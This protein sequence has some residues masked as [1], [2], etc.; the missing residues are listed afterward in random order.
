MKTELPDRQKSLVQWVSQATG[1]STFGVKV[2]LQ[3]NNLH[4]LCE[5]RE[6]PQ[7][8]R[9]LSDLLRALQQTDLDILTSQEQ[10]AIFQVFVYGRKK[11]EI[12]PK[13]CHKVYLNQLQWHLEQV[14]QALL[15][16]E[17]KYKKPSGALIVSNESLARQGDPEAI[18][19]YLSETLSTFGVAVQVKVIKQKSTENN[20]KNASRLW[21]FCESSYS[22]DLSSI[23]EPVAQKLRHLK[24]SGYQDAVIASG[25]RGENRVYWLLRV[26]LTPSEVM[27][28]EWARWGDVQALLRLL[29]EA[30]LESKVTVGATLKESTLHIFC[31]TASD[32][33]GTTP[34][35]DKILCVEAIR[36]LLEKIAPQG[37]VAATVY[38][39]KTTDSKPVWVDWLS[40]PANEHPALATSALKLGTSGDE[41]AIVF[42]LEHLLN[43]DLDSRLK[44]GGI[45]VLL[46]R[47]GD[48]LHIMCEAPVCPARTQV[49]SEVT[50]FVR[51]LEIPGIAGVRVYGRRSGNKEPFWHYGVDYKHHQRFVP[52]ATPEFA[53]TSVDVRELLL[54]ETDEPVLRPDLLTEEIYT[55]VTQ[56]TQDWSATVRKFFLR[57]QLF[58][59]NDQSQEQTTDHHQRLRVALVWGTL[60]L[61]LTLQIDWI[62]GKILADTISSTPTVANVSPKSSSSVGTSYTSETDKKAKTAFLTSASGEKSPKGENSVSN[63]SR[64]TAA[65][66]NQ[67]GNLPASP[68][69]LKAT[70]TAIFFAARSHKSEALLTQKP[71]FNARQLDEQL[72][73]YKQRLAETGHPPDVLI[74]GSSRALRG[75]D[76]V[77][78]SKSLAT[79]G[80]PSIDI[81]NFGINGATAKV[82][83]FIVRRVLKPSELPKL[84]IWADGA[85]AFNSG[86]EDMTFSAIAASP[87]YKNILGKAPEKISHTGTTNTTEQETAK[88]K[89]Q[90]G[91]NSYQTVDSWL[92]KGLAALS[93][94]YQKRDNLKNL[95]NQQLKSLLVIGD[96]NQA[97]TKK[98]HSINPEE[99]ASQQVVDFD[100]FLALSI[101]F[102]PTT[103]YQKHSQVSGNND[104]NYKSFRL[105]GDQD[106]ALQALLEFTQSQKIT[107]VF[108]NM[109]LTAY[110]LDSVRSKYEQEFQQYMLNLTDNPNF[111]YRDLS[112]LWPKTSDYF[113][114][115]S[116]LNRYGAYK[117]SKKLANDPMIPWPNKK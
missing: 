42:L 1:I 54:P 32:P 29:G 73:L 71:S 67:P 58:T 39:Q 26:D 21:I 109:P 7:R 79:Q 16:D 103:Y 47:K 61:L 34:V 5:G 19:R 107:L 9:T 8:W 40:L 96:T 18:A 41:P 2:R 24:L 33:L 66:D 115:P 69:K 78:L 100:G 62:L 108:V 112:Q 86:R 82:V 95:L 116:H 84:I 20:R 57:T 97:G 72:V 45:R 60:G 102:D 3:G 49:S 94:S 113:S 90:Q 65:N 75:I 22:P 4:I 53:A 64:L 88:K 13:W 68:L 104:N 46:L 38:G 55:F 10:P 35:P 6:C 117:V 11:G 14:E 36:P 111:I 23:A 77:A 27:L 52:E 110:Y 105:Q 50:Q 98:S 48:L 37:I 74:I 70:P 43:P 93:A 80:S 12:R 89:T 76:P 30:L 59:D 114:D 85:R 17:E 92:N 63:V 51:Q 25:V 81:F 87:G 15:E 106:T 56:V 28:K 91:N 101:R 83:D 44:T 99:D 31:T